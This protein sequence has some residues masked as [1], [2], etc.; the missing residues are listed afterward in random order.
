MCSPQITTETYLSLRI[1]KKEKG[2]D[3]EFVFNEVRAL[4]LLSGIAVEDT[5]FCH[6]KDF[7]HRTNTFPTQADFCIAVV[8]CEILCKSVHSPQGQCFQKAIWFPGQFQH[9]VF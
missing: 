4:Y 1:F 9:G 6:T 7:L 3:W 2:L 5:E 8:A